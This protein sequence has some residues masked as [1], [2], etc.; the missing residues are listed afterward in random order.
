MMKSLLTAATLAILAAAAPADATPR[1]SAAAPQSLLIV[2]DPP[3]GR[4]LVYRYRGSSEGDGAVRESAIDM[5]LEFQPA[6]DDYLMTLAYGPAPGPTPAG[7]EPLLAMLTRPITLRINGDGDIVAFENESAYWDALSRGFASSSAPGADAAGIEALQS[8]IRQIRSQPEE[9]RLAFLTSKIGPLLAY[10]GT[11]H[12]VGEPVEE[13]RETETPFGPATLTVR[14][15]LDRAGAGTAHFTT[16]SSVPADQLQR[17]TQELIARAP[18]AN[19]PAGDLRV[20]GN[21]TQREAEVDTSTGLTRHLRET[22]T[23]TFEA[24]GKKQSAETVM[25]FDRV[26][27]D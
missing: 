6:G 25:M 21:E 23:V 7:A 16:I 26:D 15:T 8:I 20:V 3:V 2:F 9:V 4:K 5:T 10:A 14:Q 1:A 18:A 19:R 22:K 12:R 24:G 27:A 13:T 17:M 11:E